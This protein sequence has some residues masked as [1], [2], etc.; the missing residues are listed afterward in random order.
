MRRKAAICVLAAAVCILL[1]CVYSLFF[2]KSGLLNSERR[3]VSGRSLENAESTVTGE[4]PAETEAGE[5]AAGNGFGKQ[6]LTEADAGG[7]NPEGE[8]SEENID[9]NDGK[10]SDGRETDSQ[11][12]EQEKKETAAGTLVFSRG[13]SADMERMVPSD[14][15]DMID[16]INAGESLADTVG[17]E[18]LEG[19]YALTT[20]HMIIA[21]DK[22]TEKEATGSGR[23]A[24]YV[25]NLLEGL[26]DVSALVYDCTEKQW[27]LIPA[28]VVDAEGKRI[29]VTMSGAG[30]VTTVHRVE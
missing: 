17:M 13:N 24:L 22:E 2:G 14:V 28:D 18:E 5:D 7:E 12:G 26:Q 23:L 4:N 27:K 25:P 11:N 21:K 3:T 19:Y 9:R 6:N 16:K 15:L 29:S 1:G 30:V 8:V 10:T 20:T